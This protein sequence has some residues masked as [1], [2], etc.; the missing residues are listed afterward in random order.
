MFFFFI[1]LLLLTQ[2]T[3]YLFSVV[4]WFLPSNAFMLRSGLYVSRASAYH[5]GASTLLSLMGSL[6]SGHVIEL[7]NETRLS[8]KLKF[9]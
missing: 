3:E 8:C 1:Y 7:E 4:S 5:M 2:Y 6:P 9:D